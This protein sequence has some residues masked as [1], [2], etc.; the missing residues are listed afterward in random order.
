MSFIDEQLIDK[1]SE[2]L[3]QE[4][5]LDVES[6]A[7]TFDIPGRK[8]QGDYATNTAMK[9]AK[10]LGTNPRALAETLVASLKEHPFVDNVEIAGP[11]FINVFVK[12]DALTAIITRIQ[13][14]DEM[15]GSSNIG[16]DKSILVEYVSANPTGQLHVGHARGAAWG[17]SLTR[18]LKFAGYKVLREFYVN[19]LGNQITMLSHSLYARYQQAYGLDATLPE[20]G[21]HGQDIIEIAAQ[22]KE[23]EGDRWLGASQEAWEPYF[24]DLGIEYELVRLKKDLAHFRVEFDSWVS[25][26][27]LYAEGRVIRALERLKTENL[28]YEQDGALWFASTNYGDDKDRVLV[29]SDGSYTYLLP[30]IGYHLYKLERGYGHLLNL[31]GGDHHGYIPRMRAALE[32]LG[33][34]DVLDVDIIQM[35]RLIEDGL[36]VKMSKR[37]GNALG[38]VDLAEDIG[39]D[40]A[41]YFFV[42]RALQTPLDFD[43]TLARSQS[44]DNPVF[45]AQYAHA[46]ICSVIKKIGTVESYDFSQLNHTKEVELMKLMGSFP[47]VVANSAKNRSVNSIPNYIQS[48]AQ[49]LHSYYGEVK[50]H[51]ASNPELMGARV[52]LLQAVRI[53]LRNAMTLIGVEAPESM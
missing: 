26:K 20:D 4:F 48:L 7:I 43:L 40:A 5:D 9:F 41:R 36:E 17:D 51:D 32:A 33:N 14:Q 46:R 42:S 25:E 29:K 8:E 11:G 30:D 3:K 44:N 21:Y 49:A 45:Y 38:L 31:W 22:V 16:K 37:T 28:T 39:V 15:F 47:D 19:D 35:V 23:D 27:S 50:I 13:E 2:T 6:G 24:K 1:L 34:V 12:P 18:L 52:Q 10:Q 53:T